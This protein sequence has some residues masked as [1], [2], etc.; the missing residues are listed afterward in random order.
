MKKVLLHA[1]PKIYSPGYMKLLQDEIILSRRRIA[2]YVQALQNHSGWAFVIVWFVQ[3]YI[4]DF[5][6]S[7]GTCAQT[8]LSIPKHLLSNVIDV[9]VAIGGW[10]MLR[11]R[12]VH[13]LFRLLEITGW[14]NHSITLA[15][16]S[17][18]FIVCCL[19]MTAKHFES[20]YILGLERFGVDDYLDEC[21]YNAQHEYNES[22]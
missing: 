15:G 21:S 1:D 7:S 8:F 9:L 22:H 17:N 6:L 10:L 13:L 18:L 19:L 11:L 16:T 14:P 3:V 2:W 12:F 20:N 5:S 4:L